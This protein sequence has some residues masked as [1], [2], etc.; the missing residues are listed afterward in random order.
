LAGTPAPFPDR[1]LLAC[2]VR[3][4]HQL[5]HPLPSARA[6]PPHTIPVSFVPPVVRFNQ[7][8][9]EL[10]RAP[11]LIDDQV[12]ARAVPHPSR[13]H[14][15]ML[16]SG[17]TSQPVQ[18]RPLARCHPPLR[19]PLGLVGQC[20][21]PIRPGA[22]ADRSRPAGTAHAVGLHA[23]IPRPR[24]ATLAAGYRAFVSRGHHSPRIPEC[25]T[26]L[27]KPKRFGIVHL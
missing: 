1:P 27:T 12:I 13:L 8:G 7:M 14:R 21:L 6:R 2:S 26:L 5:A 10:C 20:V 22:Y 17:A 16:G 18:H 11:R 4:R 15:S 9:R 3:G 23:A 24:S 25:F 19:F